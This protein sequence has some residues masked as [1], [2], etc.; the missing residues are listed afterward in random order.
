[1]CIR[2]SQGTVQGN[3]WVYKGK[4]VLNGSSAHIGGN[5]TT[6]GTASDSTGGSLSSRVGGAVQTGWVPPAPLAQ[7]P[8]PHV[9]YVP[10][11]WAGFSTRLFAPWAQDSSLPLSS[12]KTNASACYTIA[13]FSW[14]IG[15]GQALTTTS[16]PMLYDA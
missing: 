4:A 16:V 13:S 5:L 6:S 8:L 3:V 2:D 12:C 1:M 9:G 14:S 7:V 11:D 15:A 10:T